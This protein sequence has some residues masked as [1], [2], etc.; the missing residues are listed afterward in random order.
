VKAIRFPAIAGERVI[1]SAALKLIIS[2]P[3]VKSIA[4]RIESEATK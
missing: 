2:S 1:L 4:C 3:F